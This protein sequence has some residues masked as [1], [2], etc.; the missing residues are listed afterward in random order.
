MALDLTVRN[1]KIII[2]GVEVPMGK[3][4]TE[5]NIERYKQQDMQRCL[6]SGETLATDEE[7]AQAEIRMQEIYRKCMEV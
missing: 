5:L 1:T 7:Y 4:Q 6:V 3:S 2:D